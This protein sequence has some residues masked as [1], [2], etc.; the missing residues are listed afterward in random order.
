MTRRA[1]RFVSVVILVVLAVGA[2]GCRRRATQVSEYRDAIPPPAEPL[3]ID[4]PEIGRHGGRFVLARAVGPKTFNGLI[5]SETSSL[6]I[7]NQ[8]FTFLVKYDNARQEFVPGLAKTWAVAG[9]GITWTFNLRKGAAFSDGRPITADDVLFTFQVLYD[10]V[11]HPVGQEMFKVGG[12]KFKVTAPDPYT[13]VINT[14]SPHSGLIDGLV[15]LAIVPKHVLEPAYK[16]G[17]FSSAYNVGMPPDQIVTSGAWRVIRHVPGEQV[18][19]GRNPYYFGFDK[20]KQRLP[21]LDELVYLVVP[22]QDAADL[23]FRSGGV[24]GLDDVKPENYRWYEENQASGAF[25]LHNLGAALSSNIVW[26]NLNRVQPPL[27]GQKP[28]AG[29]R[30]GEPYAAPAKYE[31]F[32]T[33]VFRRAVSMAIDRDAMIKSIFFGHGEKNWSQSTSSNR[34]WHSPDL[35]KWDYNPEEAKRLLASL[36]FLDA[37]GDGVLED[38]AGNEVAFTLKT[39]SGNVLRIGMANFIRDDL[40]KVGIRMTLTPI[41]FNTLIA[42]IRS[43]FQYEAILLGFQSGVPPTPH[44]GQ[45]VWRS[46]GESHNWFIRQQK[47]ATQEEA[48]IDRLL[49]DMLTNQDRQAQKNDWK[50]I[51]NILNDQSWFVWLPTLQVQLPVSTRFGNLQPSILPH[52]IIWNIDRVFVKA[53]E[54]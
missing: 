2:G 12:Q 43:D 5:A 16:S 24:D 49:D 23:R 39:N 15:A 26:F 6:D 28:V 21:Y 41:D 52:R 42:N 9:D 37:N 11:V 47:P 33:P 14:G 4:A 50:E 34:E 10:D 22:D 35:I 53:P 1:A 25:R 54:S 32:N 3:T 36:G 31:W 27:K 8:L 40:A 18:V 38:R 29:K 17:D 20:N 46:S 48:R 44:N 51:Q 45:N 30:V 13:V 7:T 19:L